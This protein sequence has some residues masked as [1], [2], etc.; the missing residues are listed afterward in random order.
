MVLFHYTDWPSNGSPSNVKGLFEMMS[1]L[2]QW[3]KRHSGC[4]VVVHCWYGNAQCD[5]MDCPLGHVVICL[6]S[7]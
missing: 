3:Q 2:D 6:L 7:F 4:R 1:E 5:R